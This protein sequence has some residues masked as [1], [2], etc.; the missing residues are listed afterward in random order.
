M[1]EQL[2][3]DSNQSNGAASAQIQVQPSDKRPWTTPSIVTIDINEK[4]E[5]AINSGQDGGVFS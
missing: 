4:T 5:A 2:N 1:N 3:L